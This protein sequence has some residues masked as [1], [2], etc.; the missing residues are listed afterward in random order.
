MTAYAIEGNKRTLNRIKNAIEHHETRENSSE[1]WEGNVLD[2]LGI[3]F[4][5][6]RYMRG[7]IY[8]SPSLENGVL[9]FN[10]EE[11]WGRTDFADMLTKKFPSLTVYW[12]AEEPGMEIYATNDADGR[13]FPERYYVDTCV[14]G[15]YES[16]YFTDEQS[17]YEWLTEIANCKDASDVES[18]NASVTND[19]DYI[20]V[21]EF[22]IV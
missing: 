16:N 10:A 18:F 2:A 13:Y 17:V 4:S 21:H 6:D 11:A 15:A 5:N 8:E 14:N 7:F 20:Y 1:Q 9:R 19:D 22:E 3:K 12:T